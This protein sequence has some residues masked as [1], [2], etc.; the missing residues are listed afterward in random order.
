MLVGLD[1]EYTLQNP[2]LRSGKTFMQ[3][4]SRSISRPGADQACNTCG[5]SRTAVGP[6]WDRS[7]RT[8][9]EVHLYTPARDAWP[10]RAGFSGPL[11][12]GVPEQRRRIR[13][14]LS[15]CREANVLLAEPTRSPW[16]PNPTRARRP[17]DSGVWWARQRGKI[18]GEHGN[19]G[20]NRQDETR[21]FAAKG[22]AA[23]V[24]IGGTAVL[25]GTFEPGWRWSEHVKPLAKTDSCQ[26]AHAGYVLS[27]RMGIRM[28]DGTEGE[29]G[30]GDVF[31]R[32]QVTTHGR[33]AT[34][35]A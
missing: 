21:P 14:S 19:Q 18:D 5:W 10:I 16:G 27:G 13:R 4:G 23:V 32:P 11:R 12:S 34:S 6:L 22:Q 3:R 9:R 33:L 28:D 8:D 20:L 30:P 7:P 1:K 15:N 24:N 25:R 31:L 17:T 35:R 2:V 26:A 29:V